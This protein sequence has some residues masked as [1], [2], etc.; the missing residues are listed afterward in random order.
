MPNYADGHIVTSAEFNAVCPVGAIL[1]FAGS[2]APTN[3][4]IC[5][6]SAVSR[7]TFA[8]LFAVC[9]TTYGAGDGSTTFNVPDLRTRV[10]AGFKTGDANFGTR[11]GTGGAA[12]HAIT[13][14]E[15]PSH[16]H[17]GPSHT[18]TGPSHTHGVSAIV[19]NTAG[20]GAIVENR[21]SVIST[22]STPNN[23][24]SAFLTGQTDAAGTGATGASGTGATGSAGSGTAMSL[25]QPYM[26]LVY[27][28][29]A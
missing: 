5:D 16:T 20:P 29:H 24:D 12:T 25:L 14:A 15:M 6:G 19:V 2:A 22:G 18:H 3:W 13:T 27:I 9:G 10:P 17:T 1:P 8:D 28:I 26:S 4:I 7:T 21:F 23:T 11:G